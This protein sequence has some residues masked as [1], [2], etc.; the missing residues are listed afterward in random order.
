V[1]ISITEFTKKAELVKNSDLYKVYDLVLEEMVVSMTV[2]YRDKSTTGHSHDSTEEIYL[3]LE[4]KGKMQL[5]NENSNVASGDIVTIPRGIFHR[6]F[7][8]SDSKLIFL[9]VFKKYPGRGE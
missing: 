2:L 9:C 7:N 3:F 5:N 1:K 4:G 6:V 8:I